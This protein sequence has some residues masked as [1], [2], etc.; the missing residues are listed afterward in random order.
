MAIKKIGVVGCGVIGSKISQAIVSDFSRVARL[1]A[2]YDIDLEKSKKLSVFL[3]KKNLV[4][5]GLDELLKKSDFVIEASGA[6]VSK[7][8]AMKA[9][10]KGCDCMVLSVG[11][12]LKAGHLFKLAKRLGRSIYIPSGAICGIDGL[13][14]HKLANIKKVTI[15]TRKPIKALEGAPY[16]IRNKINLKA[17]KKDTVIFSGKA[18]RAVLSFPQNIN[19][20]ATL[21]LAGIGEDRTIVKIIASPSCI[22]NTHEIEI[23]SDAGRTSVICQNKPSP[24]NPKTSYLAILSA[25]A[26]LGEIFE[27]VKIGT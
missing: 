5:L 18:S 6:G 2:I 9:I 7:D 20:A 10:L 26:T 22:V 25:I 3:K 8:I 16:I 12:L 4:T 23:E 27:N 14:S 11:G 13:K 1:V 19:V 15:T 21:S 17:I 24:D